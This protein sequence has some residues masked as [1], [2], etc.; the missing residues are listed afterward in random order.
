MKVIIRNGSFK[1][2]EVTV[3]ICNCCRTVFKTD[4]YDVKPDYHNGTFY[5]STCPK[6]SNEYCHEV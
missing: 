4:E 3:F 2:K 6:C 1:E 5:V